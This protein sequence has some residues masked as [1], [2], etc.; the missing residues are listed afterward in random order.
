MERNVPNY[1]ASELDNTILVVSEGRLV[2]E[3]KLLLHDISDRYFIYCLENFRKTRGLVLFDD[4]GYKEVFDVRM[5][6]YIYPQD[7]N[8]NCKVYKSI[9]VNSFELALHLFLGV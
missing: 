4:F 7:S 2:L 1:V 8:V 6:V 9:I 5:H 3:T